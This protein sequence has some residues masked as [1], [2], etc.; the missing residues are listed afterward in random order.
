LV[1]DLLSPEYYQRYL[2]HPQQLKLDIEEAIKTQDGVLTVFIDEVQKIP[3]LMD[4][5]HLLYADYEER[6]RFLLSGSSAR[7]LKRGGADMMAGRL[8][9]LNLYPFCFSEYEQPLNDY[10]LKG[11]LPVV[12][13]HSNSASR[14]LR[15]YVTTYLKEEVL[16]ESLV[17]KIDVFSRFLELAAQYHGKI[18]NYSEL[19]SV[20]KTSS[21]SVKSYFDIL[22][23]T[24]IGFIIPGWNESTKK[25]LRL[26]PKFYL[27]DNGVAS[28]LRG[29]LQI[30]LTE[31]SSRFGDL[32][33]AM[34][35][36]E[37]LRYNEYFQLDCKFSYWRTNNGQEVD[38]LVSR[39]FGKP[40]A[41]IE[42]KSG[43]EVASKKLKGVFSFRQD[44]PEV[45]VYC[46]CQTPLP[47]TEDGIT[48]LPWQEGLHRFRDGGLFE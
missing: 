6:V 9:T 15:S 30:T 39:G 48:F 41:A 42:I 29:E 21:H 43:S 12:V 40:L 33:E 37:M 11:S 10:L 20:L 19:A 5:V 31:H 28:A 4:V 16:E 23:D 44:Y 36:Q 27:F 46:F 35:M 13:S 47:Y 34:V 8:L 2:A 17:R 45:P 1:I 14:I 22:Q 25:Q 24:L 26:A 32:F 7:K 3:A 38:L 18:I